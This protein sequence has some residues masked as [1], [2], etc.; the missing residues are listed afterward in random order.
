MQWIKEDF[1]LSDEKSLL[2]IGTI[3]GMLAGSYWAPDRTRSAIEK[4]IENS[5]CFGLYTRARQVGFARFVTDTAVFSWLMD[6]ILAEEYRGKGF[7]KWMLECLL[8]HP[9]VRETS[10]GLATLDAHDLYRKYGFEIKECMRRPR[11]Q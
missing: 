4:S 1:L 8:T 7:G 2:D 9:L 10:I 6:F 5:V 3:A 11:Q